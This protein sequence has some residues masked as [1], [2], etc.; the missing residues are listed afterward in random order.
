MPEAPGMF[1]TTIGWPSV[2]DAPSATRRAITSVAAPGPVGTIS[3]IGRLG[4]VWAF[5]VAASATTTQQSNAR[6]RDL[7]ASHLVRA[8]ASRT[9]LFSLDAG[10]A[11]NLCPLLG[12]VDDEVA[13]IRGRAREDLRAATGEP[14]FVCR[15]GQPGVDRSVELAD[16]P[17]P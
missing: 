16:E 9:E 6:K 2:R 12:I 1:S 7:T 3:L 8:A 10:R 11:D 15:S 14:G 13:E 4:Q 5:A 17:R